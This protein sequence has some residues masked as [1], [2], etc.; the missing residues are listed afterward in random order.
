LVCSSVTEQSWLE[1]EV[2]GS[3][4]SGFVLKSRFE[5]CVTHRYFQIGQLSTHCVDNSNHAIYARSKRLAG[6]RLEHEAL[7]GSPAEFAWVLA[8][9]AAGARSACRSSRQ[10]EV[11]CNCQKCQNT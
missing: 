10:D 11:R 9:G 3:G 5:I 6:S 1:L 2:Y 8:D 4:T 7:T